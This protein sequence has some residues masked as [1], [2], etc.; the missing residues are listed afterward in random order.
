MG[1]K[2]GNEAYFTVRI[3][4]SSSG[5]HLQHWVSILYY[6]SI[7]FPKAVSISLFFLFRRKVPISRDKH[8]AYM[9]FTLLA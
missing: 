9:K 5:A 8:E 3:S 7:Y 1:N 6:L 2:S 4:L